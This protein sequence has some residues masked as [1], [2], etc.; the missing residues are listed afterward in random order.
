MPLNRS[1]RYDVDDSVV[2][3]CSELVRWSGCGWDDRWCVSCLIRLMR[4]IGMK[5]KCRDVRCCDESN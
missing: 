2:T 3:G 4:D 1:K 5:V